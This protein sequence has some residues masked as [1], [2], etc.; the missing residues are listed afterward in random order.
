VRIVAISG[1]G[2]YGV[3][4]YRPEAIATSAF[5]AVSKEAGAHAILTKPFQIDDVVR[6]I[7]G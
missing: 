3:A 7:G 2:N 4:E 1:G 5:L 6:A